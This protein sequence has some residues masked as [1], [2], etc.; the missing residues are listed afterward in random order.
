MYVPIFIPIFPI[1]NQ[2][3]FCIAPHLNE[4][5]SLQTSD[6]NCDVMH[7]LISLTLA[8]TISFGLAL[9]L[10]RV[11]VLQKDNQFKG[12]NGQKMPNFGQT[13]KLAQS[14]KIAH[15]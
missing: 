10:T 7:N 5:L 11:I 6:V 8:R 9:T 15:R 4:S 1:N 14:M 3:R 13:M 2:G 12:G